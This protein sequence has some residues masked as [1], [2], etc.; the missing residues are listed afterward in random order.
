MDKK[1]ITDEIRETLREA[2]KG[3]KEEV[4]LEVFTHKEVNADYNAATV[5]LVNAIALLSPKIKASFFELESGQTNKRNVL[6]SPTVLLAP[7]AYAIKLTG[8]PLGEE[9]RSFLMSLLMIS[10]NSVILT[11]E[12]VKRLAGLK[13]QRFIEIFVSPTCPYCPQ[14]VLYGV[15]AA[16]ARPDLVSIE[17]IEI[18]EHQDIAKARGVLSVPQ[19]FVNGSLTARGAEPEDL[20]IESLFTLREPEL[21]RPDEKAGEQEVDLLI[22]GAGPAGLTAAIYAG[23]SGLSTAVIER[24][25]IGGQIMIT[26]VVENYPGF[27]SIAGR[28]LVELMAQQALQY[29]KI[30][31]SEDIVSVAREDERYVVKTNRSLFRTKGI[32]IASGADSKRLGI[33]GE[34]EFSGKGVSYCA[35]CDGYFYKDGKRVVVVGGGNTAVTEA[36]Y[37][38]GLGAKVTLVHRRGT[39]RA[40]QRLQ[41]SL[42]KTDAEILLNAEAREILGEISVSGIR[43]QN[44]QSGEVTEIPAEGVF[45]AIGYVPNSEV[46]LLLNLPVS[47]AGYIVADAHQRTALPLVY[48]AGDVTGGVKQIVVAVGQGSVAAI[49][50]FEDIASPYWI[51]KAEKVAKNHPE[52]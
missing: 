5:E 7:D 28:S 20:F 8:S 1:L 4:A 13:E 14:Q 3:L 15:S 9:G 6:R 43:V 51:D 23:R 35:E 49:S 27:A 12:S 24:R 39:L 25:S 38:H 48:A 42:L 40:E 36:L 33:P 45:L 32:I 26:P 46:A 17:V 30:R 22:V 50:A 10:A 44:T 47:E 31:L 11:P 41:D 19:T 16:I 34:Q 52:G 21:M 2:L 18:F 29:T 37:L